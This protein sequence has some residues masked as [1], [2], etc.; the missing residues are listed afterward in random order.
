MNIRSTPL[1]NLT[2]TVIVDNETDGLSSVDA[3]LPQLSEIVSLL[4]RI[5][6]T[7]R[8]DGHDCVPVFD[9]LCVACHGLSVLLTGEADTQ[10]HTA[11]FD[12]GPYGDVWVDNAVRLGVDMSTIETVFLSHWHWDHSGGFPMA[13]SA[14]ASARRAAG[15]MDPLI[16]DLH[17][18]RPDQR[19]IRTPSGTMA[20]FP[21]EPTLAS[22]ADAGGTIELHDEPHLFGGGFFLGSGAIARTTSY[23]VGLA[24]HHTFRGDIGEPDPLIMDERFVAAEV[25]GRG[26]T[27]LS[28]CSLAGIVIACLGARTHYPDLD[29]D[30]V[31]GGFHLAGANMEQRIDATATDLVQLVRPRILAPGHCT[32]WRAKAA[33]AHRFAPG[34][35]APSVVGASFSLNA[36]PRP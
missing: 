21:E 16:I 19:G 26:V 2:V 15:L 27:V 31:L 14:I 1:D 13:I 24:G 23:E 3:G 33:L 29:I 10:R 22:L 18:D 32:G 30:L 17:P 28:A 34:H 5:P 20:M 11:L 9:H 4:A 25:R 7:R 35:Y 12:V 8:H 36:L 6:P